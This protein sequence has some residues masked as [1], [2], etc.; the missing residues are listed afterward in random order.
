MVGI[1]LARS[2]LVINS[3]IGS[4]IELVQSSIFP[5]DTGESVTQNDR[6]DDITF[7]DVIYFPVLIIFN[8]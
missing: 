4:G 6:S 5:L 3:G 1:Y 7:E 2:Q 8:T